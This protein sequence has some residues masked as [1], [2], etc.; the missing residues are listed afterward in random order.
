MVRWLKDKFGEDAIPW[1]FFCATIMLCLGGIVGTVAF[2][3]I[4]FEAGLGVSIPM[5][6]VGGIGAV[7][8]G[9][10]LEAN[11]YI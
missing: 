10:I 2:A 4:G 5:I 11:G 9:V 6:I 3:V 7:P 8:T 1:V